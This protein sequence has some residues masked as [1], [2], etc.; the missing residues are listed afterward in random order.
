MGEDVAQSG[1][2]SA[3]GSSAGGK[4]TRSRLRP[5]DAGEN[6]GSSDEGW[7]SRVLARSLESATMRSLD[8]SRS[9]IDATIELLR[10]KGAGFTLDEVSERAGYSLRTFYQ[11]FES[12]DDLLLAVLEEELALGALAARREVE[13]E[14]DPVK[15]LIRLLNHFLAKA[16]ERSSHNLALLKHELGLMTTHPNEVARA[17]TPE[18]ELTREIIAE[19][20]E[21]GL[22]SPA[23]AA[24][25][26]FLVVALKRSYNQLVLLGNDLGQ[27]LPDRDEAIRFCIEGLGGRMPA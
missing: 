27:A 6:G 21:R 20:M 9:F 13:G 25:G 26:A 1:R 16:T 5:Q 4:S 22:F 24:Q 23:S 17:H 8:R 15:R 2:K 11:H 7:Q 14:P 19:G 12:K 3:K 18:S 10:E